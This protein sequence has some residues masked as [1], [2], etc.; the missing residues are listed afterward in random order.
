MTNK[1][2]E[3]LEAAIHMADIGEIPA[4]VTVKRWRAALMR[5]QEPTLTLN[6]KIPLNECLVE[7][8]N[9]SGKVFMRFEDGTVLKFNLAAAPWR[10][11]DDD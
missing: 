11:G 7:Y 5:E 4:K 9:D 8:R 3:M 6:Q 2:C 10:D 1:A